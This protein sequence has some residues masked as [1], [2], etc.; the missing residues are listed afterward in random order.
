MAGGKIVA[1][2]LKDAELQIYLAEFFIHQREQTLLRRHVVVLAREGLQFLDRQIKTPQA[3]HQP[4]LVYPGTGS[5]SRYPDPL[6]CAD[7]SRP[8][9]S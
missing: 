1:S 5:Y 4:C 8:M 2:A 7:L 9:S 6:R 3:D